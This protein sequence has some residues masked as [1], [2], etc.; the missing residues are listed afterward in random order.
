[1][2]EYAIDGLFLMQKSTGT[3]RYA[4]EILRE[5]DKLL[6]DIDVVIVVPESFEGNIEYLN[7]RAITYEK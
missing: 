6:T 3:Q 4:C 1:M 2:R 7:I 5:L